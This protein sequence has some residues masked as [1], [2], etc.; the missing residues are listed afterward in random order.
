MLMSKQPRHHSTSVR[1]QSRKFILSCLI[2]KVKFCATTSKNM[3]KTKNAENVEAKPATKLKTNLKTRSTEP[4]EEMVKSALKSLGKDGGNLTRI[5]SFIAKTYNNN[6]RLSKG[7]Q[8]QIK[9]YIKEQF[10]K[11]VILMVN[12]DTKSLNFTKDLAIITESKK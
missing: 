1:Q 3:A 9:D 12:S 5:R 4:I 2:V 8:Q 7:R 10:E 11:G 6:Q